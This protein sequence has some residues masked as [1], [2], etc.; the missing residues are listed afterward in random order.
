MS[1]ALAE[2]GGS[3]FR[4]TQVD[5]RG[6]AGCCT[7]TFRNLLRELLRIVVAHKIDS[8]PAE[9]AAGHASADEAWQPFGGLDHN[10]EFPTTDFIKIAK[11]PVGV[12]HQFPYR[13]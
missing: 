11:A 7:I 3:V 8:A 1:T 5:L 4:S 2:F 10:I 12:A 13:R 9:T 6:D